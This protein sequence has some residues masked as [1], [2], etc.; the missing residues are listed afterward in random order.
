MRWSCTAR[1]GSTRI[2]RYTPDKAI[3]EGH[4]YSDKAPG[5]VAL[6]FPGFVLA[7]LGLGALGVSLDSDTGWLVSSWVACASS[8]G[9]ITALGGVALFAWLCRWTPPRAALITT[10]AVFLGA[11]PLPYATLMF[12]H[13]LAVGL[14]GGG[15]L[16]HPTSDGGADGERDG[17]RLVTRHW[18][19]VTGI[20][21][22]GL[23][24]GGCWRA[25][26]RRD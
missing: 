9:F 17:G 4:Y 13:A 8:L 14:S 15:D 1:S 21:W 26:L 20:G 12:S 25:N 19:L 22:R 5:T 6:A 11:A 16:G 23:L 3:H 24:V 10:L 18:S 2:I 7:A